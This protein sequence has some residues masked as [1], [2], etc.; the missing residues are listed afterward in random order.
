MWAIFGV[1][2][3]HCILLML[4]LLQYTHFMV[5]NILRILYIIIGIALPFYIT[6]FNFVLPTMLFNFFLLL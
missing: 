6:D 5:A 4:Q 3:K 1:V 2:A